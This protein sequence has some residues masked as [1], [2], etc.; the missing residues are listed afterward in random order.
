M[1][2]LN[3]PAGQQC[4]INFVTGQLECTSSTTRPRVVTTP[5][6]N[7][8][9][10]VQTNPNTGQ[11]MVSQ[12]AGNPQIQQWI[13]AALSGLALFRN[14]PYVPTTT[15]PAAINSQGSYQQTLTPEQLAA[16]YGNNQNNFGGQLQSFIQNNTGVVL[17]AGVGLVLFLM[18]PPSR[19]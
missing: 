8:N 14:A 12:N 6:Y 3:I 2:A 16:L 4:S 15:Q 17:L 13:D 11:V 19:R 10:S 1:V 5:S 9:V 7:P 18:K